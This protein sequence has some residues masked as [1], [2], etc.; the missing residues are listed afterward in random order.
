MAE[1]STPESI[2]ARMRSRWADGS[3]LTAHLRG[4]TCPVLDLSLIHISR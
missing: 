1:W 3:L 2:T 4:Q